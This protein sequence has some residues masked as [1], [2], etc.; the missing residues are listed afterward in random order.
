MAETRVFHLLLWT[1]LALPAPVFLLLCVVAAPYGRHARA[2]WG[3]QLPSRLG[4]VLMELPAVL[5]FALL[6]LIAPGGP[7]T[8]PVSLL[9][10]L[11]WETHYVHRAILFPLGRR[12]GRPMPLLLAAL[13]FAF[14]V[15]NAYLNGRWLFGLRSPFPA[16]W[17]G[18]PRFLVGAALFVAG[19]A[20]NIHS[21]RILRRLRRPGETGYRIPRGGLYRFV[22]CP[23]YLGEIL[24]WGGWALATFSLPGLSFWLWT[25][26]NLL[27][28]AR[29]HHRFY[30]SRFPDYPPQRRA[31]LPFS[32]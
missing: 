8:D 32:W 27:P 12:G 17:L 20:I 21:D 31:V 26:A 16:A 1:W 4:W 9:L 13:A 30:R 7:R 6:Y 14:N 3:P 5:V 28:R 22:S 2:G 10:V 24:E 11:L 25:L 23:N 18:D 15:V 29:A 19:L